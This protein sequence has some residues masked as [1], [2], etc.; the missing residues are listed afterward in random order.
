[1]KLKDIIIASAGGLAAIAVLL[2]WYTVSLFGISASGNGFGDGVTFF[3]ILALLCGLGAVA[4]KLLPMFN[5]VN[6]K[7]DEKKTKIIDTVIGGVLALLGIIAL[8]IITSQSY[9]LASPSFGVFLLI[10]AGIA[11]AVVAWLK[12]DKTVGKAPKAKKA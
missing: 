8:I 3:G 9:G 10:L 1:M 5:I 7:V 12:I 6:I 11:I 2:P 4:W